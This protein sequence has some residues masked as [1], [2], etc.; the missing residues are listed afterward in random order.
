MALARDDVITWGGN[1]E[2]QC[3]QGA[4]RTG[5]AAKPRSLKPLQG[6]HVAQVACGYSHTLCVTATSQVHTR[7]I[8]PTAVPVPCLL[9]LLAPINLRVTDNSNWVQQASSTC[10]VCVCVESVCV[11]VEPL[12]LDSY[13]MLEPSWL[14]S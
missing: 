5:P 13:Y 6:M 4:A 9:A 7:P 12:T 11:C 2:G 10:P 14:P 3:G 1:G 8:I